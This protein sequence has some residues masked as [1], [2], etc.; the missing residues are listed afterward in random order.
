MSKIKTGLGRGLGALI[1]PNFDNNNV[2]EKIAITE[3]EIKRDDG[4]SVDVLAKISVNNIL[5]NPYQPR[6][7]FEQG[8]LDELKKS[9][10]ENGLIQPITVR[11]NNKQFELISGERRLRASKEI[12]L[13][14][15]PAYIINVNTKEA[16]I[17]LAL[18]ENVQRED[19]NAIEVAK[20]YRRLM[21]E[22]NMTQ[23]EIAEKVGKERSTITNFMRLLKLPDRIQQG[24]IDGEIAAGHARA[25][26]GLSD[27]TAQLNLFRKIIKEKLSVR[28]VEKLVKSPVTNNSLKTKN[29]ADGKTSL[30]YISNANIEERLRTILGT[31]VIC[32][33]KKDGS[34]SVVVEFYSEDELERLLDLFESIES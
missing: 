19:L 15:I 26:L 17:A 10:L 12:G 27:E 32:K 11:R 22:C 5:P 23:E 7:N 13:K 14:E 4:V 21:V 9:I 30:D 28:N 29:V 3:S 18:I 20:T 24:L 25:L 16:M 8:A 1:N 2:D 6:T 33:Q 34:G 31:K